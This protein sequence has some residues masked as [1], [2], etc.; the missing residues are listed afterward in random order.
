MRMPDPNALSSG[1][2]T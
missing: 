2:K 1:Q